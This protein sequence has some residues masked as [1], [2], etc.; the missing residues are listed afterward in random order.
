MTANNKRA[1]LYWLFKVASVLVSVALPILAVLEKYPLWKEE[2]GVIRSVGSGG[3]MI[4]VVVLVVFRRTVFDFIRDHLSL[5]HAPPITVW[6]VMICVTHLL[7]FIGEVMRDM[8]IVFWM[9]LLGCA[10][11]T[12]LTYI[13]ERFKETSNDES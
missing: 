13:S 8:S 11:G 12:I 3:I 5:K 2:H 1:L 6:I 10:I 9:G 4:I 7:V